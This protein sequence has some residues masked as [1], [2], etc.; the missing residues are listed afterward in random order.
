MNYIQHISAFLE[1]AKTDNRLSAHHITLYIALFYQWNLAFFKNP[2]SIA[3]AETKEMAKIGSNHTYVKCM[4]DLHRWGYIR[5]KTS[6]N[7]QKGS[8]VYLYT[9]DTSNMYTF[10]TSSVHV[11]H[12]SINNTN[13][14]KQESVDTHPQNNDAHFSISKN[15]DMETSE[16]KEKICAKKERN[17]PGENQKPLPPSLEH[18][19][20]YFLEKGQ[21]QRE[22]EK[23]FNYFESNGWLVGGKAK[24]KDWKAAARNWMLNIPKFSGAPKPMVPSATNL[25]TNKRYD[26]PL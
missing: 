9:F 10:D 6:R 20:I 24:M 7:P 5:Y 18:V 13:Y 1:Q 19:T 26:E 23:F 21:P 14:L 12:P 11:V 17:L 25:N 2:I 22:A 16:K 4:N 3:R 8:L 15:T